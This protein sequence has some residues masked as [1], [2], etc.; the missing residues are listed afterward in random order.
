MIGG[1][2]TLLPT[3]GVPR[4]PK[5]KGGGQLWFPLYT[6]GERGKGRG[7]G[8]KWDNLSKRIHNCYFK[9]PLNES[10]H[11][12]FVFACI[13]R[14][15]PNGD[16]CSFSPFQPLHLFGELRIPTMSLKQSNLMTPRGN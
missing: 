14:K 6:A 7:R 13:Q 10:L 4:V 15:H 1:V 9:E 2:K 3:P 5:Q 11:N 12:A 8:R 16:L